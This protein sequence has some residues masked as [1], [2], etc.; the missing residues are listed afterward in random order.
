M[1]VLPNGFLSISFQSPSDQPEGIS[2]NQICKKSSLLELSGCLFV[3]VLTPQFSK[4]SFCTEPSFPPSQN[5]RPLLGPSIHVQ[6]PS[7]AIVTEISSSVV[8]LS[9]SSQS[10]VNVSLLSVPPRN[11]VPWFPNVSFIQSFSACD[12]IESAYPCRPLYLRSHKGNI[13]SSQ[14]VFVFIDIAL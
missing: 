3:A 2:S 1:L 5:C 13:A 12:S 4:R 11:T 6:S 8:E 14:F 10:Y 9:L 7:A